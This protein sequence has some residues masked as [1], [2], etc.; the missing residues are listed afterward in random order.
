MGGPRRV[1]KTVRWT[2][3]FMYDDDTKLLVVYDEVSTYD[4]YN[5]IFPNNFLLTWVRYVF[6]VDMARYYKYRD[7]GQRASL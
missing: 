4:Q 6:R 2:P 1:E 5:V 3:A 7:P